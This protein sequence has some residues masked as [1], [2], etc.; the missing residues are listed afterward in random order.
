[1]KVLAIVESP[2]QLLCAYEMLCMFPGK[3]R[4]I[5]KCN[6]VEKNDSQMEFA[7]IELGLHYKKVLTRQNHLHIDSLRTAIRCAPLLLRSYEYLF[8][9]DYFSR[10][11][12]A[13]ACLPRVRHVYFLDDGVA[14]YLAQKRMRAS[15]RMFSIATFLDVQ[16]LPGQKVLRHSFSSIRKRFVL[17]KPRGCI[18][19]GQPLTEKGF[20]SPD[21][22]VNLVRM[23]VDSGDGMLTYF[24][25]RSESQD[26]ISCIAEIAGVSVITPE[27]CIELYLL[28]TRWC[29]EKVFAGLSSA[30]FS[31][32]FVFPKVA[33]FALIPNT[34]NADR[35]PHLNDI[36]VGLKRMSNVEVI[37]I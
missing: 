13:L 8:L 30:I 28:L 6:G 22:Y 19:L 36:L 12:R 32:S 25:H 37:K 4:L 31:L 18:F 1:M 10:I 26:S 23:A 2:L 34:L 29:P 27:T 9:G 5:L 35:V 33:I 15:G 7:A 16:P 24:P 20:L 3:Y 14:T 17:D 21:S 11:F